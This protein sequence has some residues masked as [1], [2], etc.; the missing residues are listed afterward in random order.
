MTTSMEN[1]STEHMVQENKLS[2]S[3]A[4]QRDI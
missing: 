4:K 3:K 2:I 1:A